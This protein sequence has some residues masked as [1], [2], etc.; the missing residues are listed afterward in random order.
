MS[1]LALCAVVLALCVI[2]ISRYALSQGIGKLDEK[3]R[4]ADSTQAKS[5]QQVDQ[6]NKEADKTTTRLQQS[7]QSVAPAPA[8]KDS[9]TGYSVK[10]TSVGKRGVY[11][12]PSL[13]KQRELAREK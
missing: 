3:S 8:A 9:K 5:W 11:K 4:V 6:I 1:R 13:K 10:G 2:P 12:K 7:Q